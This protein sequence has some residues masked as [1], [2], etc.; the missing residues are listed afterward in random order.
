M[1]LHSNSSKTMKLFLNEKLNCRAFAGLVKP[2]STCI[3]RILFGE[4]RMSTDQTFVF[5]KYDLSCFDSR[6]YQFFIRT[7]F[8]QSSFV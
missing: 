2:T 6:L 8:R 5:P 1:K 7:D 3:F 4:I